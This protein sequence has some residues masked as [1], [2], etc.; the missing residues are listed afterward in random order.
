MLQFSTNNCAYTLIFILLLMPSG[1][2]F[3]SDSVSPYG[4]SKDSI[5]GYLNNAAFIGVVKKISGPMYLAE[6]SEILEE[7]TNL[8]SREIKTK[9]AEHLNILKES[10]IVLKSFSVDFSTGDIIQVEYFQS[11]RDYVPIGTARVIIVF[12]QRRQDGNLTL[13]YNICGTINDNIDVFIGPNLQTS[14]DFIEYVYE[15][16]RLLCIER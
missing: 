3:S 6:F 2:T 13:A 16:K 10:Y 4:N 14:H 15:K 7:N 8:S 1:K 12:E 5:T 9:W 11:G